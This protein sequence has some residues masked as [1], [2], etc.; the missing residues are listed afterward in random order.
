MKAITK[1]LIAIPAA[2]AAAAAL[3]FGVFQPRINRWGLT[4]QEVNQSFPGD[5]LV[6]NPRWGFKQAITIQAPASVVFPWLVQMGYQR[7]GWYSLDWVE[8]MIG[9]GDFVDG[10]H[11]SVRI[12]PELQDLADGDTIKIAPTLPYKVKMLEPDRLLVLHACGNPA[13]PGEDLT[14]SDPLPPDVVNTSWTFYLEPVDA[15][16][17]RLYVR[18]VFDGAPTV[19]NTI[20]FG[21]FTDGGALLMSPTQL[22]GIRDR[23]EAQYRSMS[24]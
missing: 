8:N 14:P 10:K 4:D 20:A 21:M 11:A 24:E 13:H 2:L 7:A 18:F 17:T 16:T 15:S 6:P 19:A 1:T 5:E 22:K 23:A 9:A 12:V 3:Y